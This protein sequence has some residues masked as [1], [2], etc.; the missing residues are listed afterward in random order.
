MQKN[1]IPYLKSNEFEEEFTPN[2]FHTGN[3]FFTIQKSY[4]IYDSNRKNMNYYHEHSSDFNQII[5]LD[6]NYIDDGRIYKNNNFL[7]TKDLSSNNNFLYSSKNIHLDDMNYQKYILNINNENNNSKIKRI[8][9]KNN[10]QNKNISNTETYNII[11]IYEAPPLELTPISENEKNESE[12]IRKPPKYY[13]KKKIYS[14]EDSKECKNKLFDLDYNEL[15]KIRKKYENK[16]QNYNYNTFLKNTKLNNSKSKKKNTDENEEKTEKNYLKFFKKFET[17]IS[18]SAININSKKGKKKDNTNEINNYTNYKINSNK[19]EKE[20]KENITKKTNEKELTEK[21]EIY[22]KIENKSF[23]QK[24]RYQISQNLNKDVEIEQKLIIGQKY[25]R[26][27]NS[28]NL[29]KERVINDKDKENKKDA[30]EKEEKEKKIFEKE[31][32]EDNKENQNKNNINKNEERIKTDYIILE[33]RDKQKNNNKLEDK[34]EEKPL[35]NKLLYNKNTNPINTK[36]DE[37]KKN[38]KKNTQKGKENKTPQKITIRSSLRQIRI[39]ENNNGLID[40]DKEGKK[41]KNNILLNIEVDKSQ[42]SKNKRT[43]LYSKVEREVDTAKNK[44]KDNKMNNGQEI[45]NNY[46]KKYIYSFS[47][48]KNKDEKNEKEKIHT[49]QKNIKN[50]EQGKNNDIKNEKEPKNKIILNLQLE[51]TTSHGI[52]PNKNETSKK[53]D[54][55]NF[56][57]KKII[58]DN[59]NIGF[60]E[61]SKSSDKKRNCLTTPIHQE[62]NKIEESKNN[63]FSSFGNTVRKSLYNINNSNNN[64]NLMDNKMNITNNMKENISLKNNINKDKKENT[65]KTIINSTQKS[66]YRN[67]H[68]YI[69]VKSLGT[70]KIN[71]IIQYKPEKSEKIN[72]NKKIINSEINNVNINQIK[73]DVSPSIMNSNKNEKNQNNTRE[74][75]RRLTNDI[76]NINNN[77]TIISNNNCNYQALRTTSVKSV[78]AK[79]QNNNDIVTVKK[80]PIVGQNN[81]YS[82]KTPYGT[83]TF[84]I[85]NEKKGNENKTININ[86]III[87]NN[88]LNG[89]NNYSINN[90]NTNINNNENKINN[91]NNNF[92]NINNNRRDIKTKNNHS[93]Y[94]S[95]ALKK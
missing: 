87:K 73:N 44:A 48:E 19:E 18:D 14:L 94:V 29:I 9:K 23:I 71:N 38:D 20:E 30:N 84:K 90:N 81:N 53:N 52:I 7:E 1:Y 74:N 6:M 17:K 5:P 41:E 2:H 50:I 33:R 16:N 62:N 72:V 3:D 27:N 40:T 78:Y 66:T 34:I 64:N 57:E 39:N 61:N 77:I 10:S 46:T 8:N 69:A 32:N 25:I 49:E 24:P 22:K 76:D 11:Q 83:N 31:N 43:Y 26:E 60:F 92:I 13:R 80:K 15:E 37:E 56:N 89:I 4:N 75:N 65:L 68:N 42:L 35:V 58:K 85:Q 28:S 82:M 86:N 51:N 63:D 45:K 70:K 12:E 55:Q 54:N 21:S 91:I 59:S 95:I 36:Y 88:E 67:N 79:V 47:V 93:L